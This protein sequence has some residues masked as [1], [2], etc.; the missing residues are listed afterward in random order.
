MV[1]VRLVGDDDDDG[2]I[3]WWMSWKLTKSFEDQIRREKYEKYISSIVGVG[4]CVC[5]YEIKFWYIFL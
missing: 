4:I 1:C 3:W 2:G 5:M